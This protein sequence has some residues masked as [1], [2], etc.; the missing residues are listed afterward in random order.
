M[1]LI[2]TLSLSCIK[3]T[4]DDGEVELL[5]LVNERWELISGSQKVGH[6]SFLA[7]FFILLFF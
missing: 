3:I 4:Y 7:R 2:V 6:A 1:P 5:Q